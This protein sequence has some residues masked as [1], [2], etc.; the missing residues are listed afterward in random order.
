MQGTYVPDVRR[1]VGGQEPTISIPGI[2]V[3]YT[4]VTPE[5]SWGQLVREKDKDKKGED[6]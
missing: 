2:Y 5:A 4:Y 1:V 6:L 3:V